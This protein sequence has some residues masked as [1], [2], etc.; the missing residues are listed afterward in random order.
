MKVMNVAVVGAGIYGINHVNA[1]TWNPNTNLVAVCDLN[2]E[3]TDKIAKQ[4]EVCLLY[5]SNHGGR[6]IW[7]I[8]YQYLI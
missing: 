8:F 7:Q 6:S 4:Y 5:T 1:Y 2:K 3:I